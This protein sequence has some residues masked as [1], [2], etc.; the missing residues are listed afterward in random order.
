MGEEWQENPHAIQ[1]IEGS[2]HQVQVRA[3]PAHTAILH[4]NGVVLE[5]L[6]DDLFNVLGKA[7]PVVVNVILEIGTYES[8]HLLHR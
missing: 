2:P 3:E 6:I 4:H 1:Y 5:Q 8:L 7:R